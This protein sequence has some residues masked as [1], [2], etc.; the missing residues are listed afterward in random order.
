MLNT[1]NYGKCVYEAGNDVVDHQVVNVEYE[2]GVTASL[3]M[4]ACESFSV[5]APLPTSITRIA[6]TNLGISLTLVTEAQCDR[7]TKIQGTKGELIGDMQTFV[8]LTSPLR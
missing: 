5:F 7:G 3:T 6:T 1:T 8:S 4:S 2:G